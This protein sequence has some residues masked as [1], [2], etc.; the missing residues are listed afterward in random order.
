MSF[1]AFDQDPRF[2]RLHN[3]LMGEKCV[4]CQLT[5]QKVSKSFRMRKEEGIE[6]VD[7]GDAKV[8]SSMLTCSQFSEEKK[9][10]N[11]LHRSMMF[12]VNN[13]EPLTPSLNK[14]YL[15]T[16]FLLLYCLIF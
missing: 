11:K 3:S 16:P 7:K 15:L 14:I 1:L 5:N 9:K 6:A 10:S 13:P 2:W 4:S 12:V 8:I